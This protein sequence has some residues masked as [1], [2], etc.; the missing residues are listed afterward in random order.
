MRTAFIEKR[1]GWKMKRSYSAKLATLVAA[2]TMAAVTITAGCR[3]KESPEREAPPAKLKK[4]EP[5]EPDPL[6]KKEKAS[7]KKEEGTE[8]KEKAEPADATDKNAKDKGKQPWVLDIEK[9]TIANDNY[10]KVM[11]TGKYMQMVFMSLKPGEKIDLELHNDH[12]QFIRIEQGEGRIQMGKS[13]DNLSFDEK[14]SH[15]WALF[16]PAGYWHKFINI[17]QKDLKLYSIYAP[18][19][20]SAGLVHKNYDDTEGHEH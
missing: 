2:F 4:A 19:V 5:A 9:D 7:A 14:V 1:G 12:D 17:G 10:R 8:K 13:K 20:H 15:D 3:E 11:W 18:P 16:I 6:E